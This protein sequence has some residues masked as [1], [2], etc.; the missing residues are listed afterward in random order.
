M[1][2]TRKQVT[3]MLH[4]H[5]RNTLKVL[6]LTFL[7]V[8]SQAV[9]AQNNVDEFL[10]LVEQN[11]QELKA[12]Y[13]LM[14]AQQM[15]FQ[16]GLT[17]DNPS[18]EYGHFPGK[19]EEIGNKTTYG[20][21][22]SFDFP[23]VYS[24]R[25]KLA[26]DQSQ[27]SE[28]EYQLFRQAKLLEA[29][30]G[31]YQYAF[32]LKKQRILQKRLEHAEQ[33]YQSYQTKFE[34][35]NASVLDVNKARIQYLKTKSNNQLLVQELDAQQRDLQLL[36]GQTPDTLV[37]VSNPANELPS[38]ETVLSDMQQLQPEVRYL[39]QAQQVADR[40]IK[41]AKQNWLPELE[42]GYESE[43][44]G[45]GTYRGVRGG[46]SIPLWKD[47]NKVKQA[48]AQ[49]IFE[50]Q[51]YSS[52]LSSLV[53]ETQKRYKQA[54]ELNKIW[55][56]Y[57]QT[58]KEAANIGFLDKALQLGH[59]SVIDYFNELAFYYETIDTAMEIENNYIQTLAK[60]QAYKL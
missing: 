2:R 1:K 9:Y 30:L 6:L 27:L 21:S 41:L 5:K 8:L 42:L 12:A 23:T 48:K 7:G 17:P 47:K 18:I 58:L 55:K 37:I 29:Q 40:Q 22:Q 31:F 46:L 52:R 39:Q 49:A 11:N 15:G 34:R 56:E 4:Q 19:Q 32:L 10:S 51:R 43:K 25:K 60:L 14:E 33:L 24:V 16:T 35:G 36:S 26:N 53:S 38:L 13:K 20:I 3:A 57:D 45:D 50:E 54:E 28:Y 59:L 44:A